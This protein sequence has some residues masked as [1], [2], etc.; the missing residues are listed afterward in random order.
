MKLKSLAFFG[1]IMLSL[2]LVTGSLLTAGHN[3]DP[4][5]VLMPIIFATMMIAM[6]FMLR[7]LNEVGAVKVRDAMTSVRTIKA[8]LT[9]ATTK[10]VIY[11][12]NGNP[13]LAVNSALANVENVFVQSGLIEYAKTNAQAW[14][15]GDRIYW[16]VTNSVFTNVQVATSILAGWAEVPAA[17][18]SSTGFVILAP[19]IGQ[20]KTRSA[21]ALSDAA[22]TLTATQLIDK[23]L[24]TITPSAGRALTLDTAALLVAGFPGAQVG[25]YFDFSVICLAAFAATI[26]TAAGLTLVGSMAVTNQ[27]GL[28]RAVFTNVGSGTEAVTVYRIA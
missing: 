6:P 25:D 1:L 2:M 23:G 4:S 12:V 3:L 7:H 15:G 17:N 10:D 27:S 9:V 18:P 24:F 11:I 5:A 21:T 22:A 28:F 26:T 8:T 16:D 14:L 13:M 20:A 19:K